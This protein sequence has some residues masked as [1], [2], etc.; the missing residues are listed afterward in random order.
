MERKREL[1]GKAYDASLSAFYL[2]RWLKAIRRNLQI[3]TD[4]T[5]SQGIIKKDTNLSIPKTKE[6]KWIYNQTEIYPHILPEEQGMAGEVWALERAKS[7][8]QVK[9]GFFSFV[10]LGK[11][12]NF[13]ETEFSLGIGDWW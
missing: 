7:G 2:G 6:N 9:L 8:Y 3:S 10:N 5:D 4:K 1:K 12:L 11:S 13:Y